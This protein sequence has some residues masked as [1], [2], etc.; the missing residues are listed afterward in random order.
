MAGAVVTERC[1][2]QSAALVTW[3]AGLGAVTAEAFARRHDCGVPS[4]RARLSVAERRG[5]LK[6]WRP[7][8]EQPA[9]YTATRAGLRTAGVRGIDP[10]RVSPG[11]A[12]H[13]VLCS[14]CAAELDRLYPE[15]RVIGEP[16]L[17]LEERLGGSHI[18]SITVPGADGAA[19]RP[20]LALLPLGAGRGA[21]AVEVELTV[22]SP[23][24]LGS[25]CQSWARARHVEGV[26]YLASD[27]V[28]PALGRAIA[29]SRAAGRIVVLEIERLEG[30]DRSTGAIER[31]I[32]GGA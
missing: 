10:A 18:A 28:R 22:K 31:A 5:L 15:H 13:A 25:I 27:A 30:A 19:H 2:Q 4:A 29:Q 21:I 32:A 24:R 11:G 8:R 17:R 1:S 12:R 14:L 20:D 7:L 3:V 16:E 6:S 9:L 23:R 26:I